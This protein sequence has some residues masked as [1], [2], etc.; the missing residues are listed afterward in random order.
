MDVQYAQIEN[1]D[2]QT[3]RFSK[4]IRPK[5]LTTVPAGLLLGAGRPLLAGGVARSR[6][7]VARLLPLRQMVPERVLHLGV[8][9]AVEQSYQEPLADTGTEAELRL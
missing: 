8:E 2:R 1:L 5:S 4:S 9:E 6:T 7:D 3:P